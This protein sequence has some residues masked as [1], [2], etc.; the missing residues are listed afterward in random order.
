MRAIRESLLAGLAGQLGHPRGVPGRAV[1]GVLNRVN[2]RTIADAVDALGPAPGDV[3]ADFGFG[4]GLGL[5]LLLDRVGESGYVHGIEFSPDM[6][7]RCRRRHRDEPRL[8][9]QAGSILELPLADGAIDCAI[10]VNTLYFLPDLGRAA[11]E[12]TRVLRRGGRLVIGVGDPEA[13]AAMPFIRA[14]PFERHGFRLRPVAEVDAALE[15]AGLTV[16]DHRRAGDG[17]RAPHLLVARRDR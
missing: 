9:L 12:L 6:L 17:D 3:A 5:G 1:A 15:A 11:A 8:C 7:E 10:T 16:I 13:M 14:L 4:G 2:N